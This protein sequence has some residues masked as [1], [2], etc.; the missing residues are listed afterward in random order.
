[1]DQIQ[2]G[3]HV[4]NF[5]GGIPDD[6]FHLAAH[7]EG[8]AVDVDDLGDVARVV[9]QR[10]EAILARPERCLRLLEVGDIGMDPHH[11]GDGT[12][13]IPAGG[14]PVPAN[15]HPGSILAQKPEIDVERVRLSGQVI[16]EG[17]QAKPDIL[18]MHP[19]G[20][21]VEFMRKFIRLIPR[22]GEIAGIVEHATLRH[23]PIPQA[24]ARRIHGNGQ[25]LLAQTQFLF[26][27][28]LLGDIAKL[29]HANHFSPVGDLASLQPDRIFLSVF[30]HAN[31]LVGL[32]IP[33]HDLAP[34]VIP[35]LLRNQQQPVHSDQ[36]LEWISGDDRQPV[37]AVQNQ[38]LVVDDN[39]AKRRVVEG[40][41]PCLAFLQR[42]QLAVFRTLRALLQRTV[43][44][45]QGFYLPLQ[46][47]NAFRHSPALRFPAV[48]RLPASPS[49]SCSLDESP[50]SVNGF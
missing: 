41:E 1:M 25:P 17:T 48:P 30:P 15:P 47:F 9:H 4:Q 50:F 5:P 44:L 3:F 8:L 21:F 16:L 32:F 2:R 6:F 24:R 42:R 27:L 35:R 10:P 49:T 43:F 14:L 20:P 37:V 28:F 13:R 23:V 38:A 12:L 19:P 29:H 36:F 7:I 11:A 31:G 26:R 18:R 45:A 22:H 33:G 40:L 46:N 34:H 39:S